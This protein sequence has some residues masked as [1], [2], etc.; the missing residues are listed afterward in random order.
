MARHYHRS[1]DLLS[2]TEVEAY[3]LHLVKDRKLSYSSVNHA[4][5]A[6]RFLFETVLGRKTDEHLR[7]PMARV[8]QTQPQLL[9]RE[10]IARLF[11]CCSHPVYRMALQTIYAT[12]LRVSEACCL[13]VSDIDSAADRMCVRV[14]AGKGGSDRYSILSPTLLALLRL[15]CQTYRPQRTPGK[16]LFANGTRERAVGVE[17]LQRAYQAAKHCAGVTKTGGTH[18]LRHGFATHLLEGGTDLYTISRLLGHGH[19]STTARYLHLISPQFRPPKDVDPLD[20][21]AGLPKL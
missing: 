2:P 1:P 3:L 16:W 9:A 8:P 21:L 12:G 10:E 18:T 15:Y 13:R 19:I 20:L 17:S 7:P 4:A 5:S 14:V 11:A 6:S